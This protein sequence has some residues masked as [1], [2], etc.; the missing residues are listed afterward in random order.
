MGASLFFIVFL[1]YLF[2]LFLYFLNF[3]TRKEYYY[4]SARKLIIFSFLLHFIFLVGIF[5]PQKK[6]PGIYTLAQYLDIASLFMILACFI[7]EEK[8]KTR[9]L[10]L[11]SLP[12][13]L[14]FC[15]FAI[16]LEHHARTIQMLP[17][18]SGLLWVHM[19]L[20]L[21]AFTSFIISVSSAVMYL[22]Q[23]AQLK[24]KHLG[25]S[26]LRLPSL[27]LL[28]RVH[29]V[30]L[31]WGVFMF[32]IGILS[33][34]FLTSQEQRWQDLFRDPKVI[35]SFVTCIMYWVVLSLRMSSMRRG[36]KIA[37]GTVAIFVLLFLTMMSSFYA[38]SIFHRGI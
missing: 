33:G 24:S 15:F 19:S 36:Q 26:F 23:S 13:V 38:P 10:M 37:S 5:F 9:F 11:F 29:F 14:L 3:E 18:K 4:G 2:S 32:S 12:I 16:L 21:S 31:F 17:E 30:S 22:L 35:L 7:V 8:L 34:F 25:Q 6:G 27:S 1:G 20:L 28:D